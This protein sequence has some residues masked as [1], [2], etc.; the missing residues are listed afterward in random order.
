MSHP[1]ARSVQ[2]LKHLIATNQYT[3]DAYA[4]A[5]AMLRR[6]ELARAW[7]LAVN[8][9]RARSLRALEAPSHPPM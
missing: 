1:D 3:V 2:H 6:V 8:R 9:S 4:V 5:D 7:S